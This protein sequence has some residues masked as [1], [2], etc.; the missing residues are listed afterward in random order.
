M[1]PTGLK[2]L[3]LLAR[4]RIKITVSVTVAKVFQIIMAQI[5]TI[6]QVNFKH[7]QGRSRISV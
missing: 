7:F 5:S 3:A 4:P 1:T 6:L 2:S